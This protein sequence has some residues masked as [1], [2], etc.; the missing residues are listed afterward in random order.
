MFTKW[1]LTD[2]RDRCGNPRRGFPTAVQSS[3]V[4]LSNEHAQKYRFEPTA[5]WDW[6]AD[7]WD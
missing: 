7:R 1:L 3:L 5:H 6:P 4:Y 2:T